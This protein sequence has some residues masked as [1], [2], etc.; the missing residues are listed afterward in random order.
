MQHRTYTYRIQYLGTSGERG[1]EWCTVTVHGN[2]DRTIRARSEIDDSEILRDV[3][4][5]V[6]A[7]WFPKD[8]FVRVSVGDRFVGSS[9]F[10][11]NGNRVEC[12]GS[13]AAEGRISQTVVFPSR[14]PAFVTHPVACDVWHFAGIDRGK[15]GV[16][17]ESVVASCSPLPNGASGPMLGRS[18]HRYRYR[19]V[20]TVECPAGTFECEHVTYVG[21][22]GDDRMD[23]WCTLQDRVLIKMHFPVLSTTY[24]LQELE[25]NTED[26]PT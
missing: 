25:G 8:A 4:A 24:W 21:K 2:G 3:T 13:T 11:F 17:Q 9:W 14:P 15:T 23:A 18:T 10:R 22:D 1:R 5:T 12:E 19:G 20:E 26:Q 6:D 16:V 7:M